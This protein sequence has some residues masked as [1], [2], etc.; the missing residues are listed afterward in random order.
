MKQPWPLYLFVGLLILPGNGRP[1]SQWLP[2]QAEKEESAAAPK[3]FR[4]WVRAEEWEQRHT[5]TGSGWLVESL[6]ETGDRDLPWIVERRTYAG[7]VR[8]EN[9]I[10]REAWAGDRL[11]VSSTLPSGPL[12]MEAEARLRGLGLTL[13]RCYPFS[14][15]RVYGLPETSLDAA[16]QW[17]E[18]LERLFTQTGVTIGK[19]HLLHPAA[20]I[21]DDALFPDQWSLE[22][23]RA[24]EGWDFA[25]GDREVVVAVLDTGLYLD[26]EDFNNGATTNLWMNPEDLPDGIDN[27]GNGLVDDVYGWDFVNN[28]GVLIGDTNGHGTMV[29]GI[30]GAFGNNGTGIAGVAWRTRILPLRCGATALPNSVLAQSMDYVTDLRLRGFPVVATS[31]SY[32]YYPPEN[33]SPE[34]WSKETVL[35]QAIERARQAGILVITA[36]GNGG[37]NNDSPYTRHFYPSDSFQH[38]V[39]SVNALEPNGS[40]WRGSNYGAE[41]VDLAAPGINVLTTY[42]DGAYRTWSGTSMAAPHASGAAALLAS[43]RPGLNLSWMR[44]LL[45]KTVRPDPSLEGKVTTG[46]VLDLA[47][48]LEVASLPLEEAWK[49]LHW[50]ESELA[51]M[52]F[53][54]EDNPDGDG[55]THLMELAF[56]GDPRTA[57]SRPAVH[58][59]ERTVPRGKSN[60]EATLVTL[61]HLWSPLADGFLARY[62]EYATDRDGPW[63]PAIPRQYEYVGDDPASGVRMYEGE[64]QL[65]QNPALLRLRL[66][67][68]EQRPIPGWGR[69]NHPLSGSPGTPFKTP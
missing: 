39:L 4:A 25:T 53:S 61:C 41:S 36:S 10:H 21:P 46:G 35:G 45:L 65:P 49:R 42:N 54:W 48:M 67:I 69:A 6:R 29:S 7:P 32:G 33:P 62:F 27:D 18:K 63:R 60:R 26:H 13:L 17:K 52:T 8:E 22:E 31:N 3:A 9:L 30:L 2:D 20:T 55:W 59:E 50:T 57:D 12:D 56:G 28:S 14:P 43:L 1:V 68:G 40:L 58:V 15:V 64:F 23:I 37:Q 11:V 47:R 34:E 5:R 44:A 16:E 51:Q 19:D 66:E 24:P 38:N